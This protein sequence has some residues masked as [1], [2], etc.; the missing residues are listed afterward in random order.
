M[1]EK[2]DKTAELLQAILAASEEK[3]DHAL[4]ILRGEVA[5]L[6]AKPV[7]GPLL[8]GMG[9]AARFVGCSRS[10]LWRVLQAG[11]IQ[12]VELFPG[13]FRVRR[14]DLIKLAEGGFGFSGKV[15]RRG[16]PRKDARASDPRFQQLK[17]LADEGN[18]EAAGDLFKEFEYDHEAGRFVGTD[19]T[20]GTDDGGAE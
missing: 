10:T 16:R 12:K 4:R 1:T 20:Q 14:E 15:S 19:G 17:A 5:A 11:T 6:P 18:E 3:K 9:A 13:S 7:V 8:M 2:T